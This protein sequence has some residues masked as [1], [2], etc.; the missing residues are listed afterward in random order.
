M[1]LGGVAHA[2]LP[3][4]SDSKYVSF[5]FQVANQSAAP[6]YVVLVFPWSLSNGAPTREHSLVAD[7]TTVH[8]GRRVMDTPKLFAMKQTAYETWQAGLKS[9]A[10]AAE[11][12]AL[13]SSAQVIDCNTELRPRFMLSASDPAEEIL[14]RYSVKSIDDASC[15][16]EA[17][18]EPATPT[19]TP[20]A[21]PAAKPE[22]TAS[23]NDPAPTPSAT[24]PES[25]STCS[26]AAR[27]GPL[28]L[29][30]LFVIGAV[31]RRRR[32]T[33]AL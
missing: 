5:G 26:V 31:L 19:A 11:L 15:V 2:D 3:P 9:G 22:K 8:V 30:G 12:D 10:T 4:P 28:G 14:D 13:F 18:S 24:P 33:L 7:A 1:L 27:P 23:A 32:S 6:D 17:V 25:D 21:T 16:I 20:T 29:F